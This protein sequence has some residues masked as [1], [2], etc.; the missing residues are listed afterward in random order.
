MKM[1][2]IED[3]KRIWGIDPTTIGKSYK[4][5]INVG[6]ML[7]VC[8]E[9]HRLID[10][11]LLQQRYIC[12]KIKGYLHTTLY[13]IYYCYVFKIQGYKEE[14]STYGI[15]GVKENHEYDSLD[16]CYERWNTYNAA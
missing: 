14:Y 13:D 5:F 12:Q 3:I 6:P 1:K 16:R 7:Y 9:D 15:C 2:T 11:E 4:K 10:N 8:T